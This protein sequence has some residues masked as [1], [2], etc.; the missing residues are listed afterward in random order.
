MNHP[1]QP[2]RRIALATTLGALLLGTLGAALAPRAA[3]AQSFPD[4]P[5]HFIIPYTPGGNTDPVVR[6]LSARMQELLGQPLVL[7]YKPGA[8]T[9]I[10]A[11]FVA[12]S[13]PDGYTLFLASNSLAISPS[14]YKNLSYDPLRDLI[15][16]G[17]IGDSPFTL[18]VN[19][20]LAVNNVR[21]L[22]AYAKANPGKLSFGS[23]GNG[24][25]VHLGMELFKSLAGVDMLHVPYNGG[26]PQMNA[27]LAGDIQV[28]L[29]PASNFVQHVAT[30]RVRM[31]AVASRARVPGL[32]LPTVI[33]AGVPGYQS[34]V[35]MALY[36]ASGT[37][38][39]VIDKLNGALNTALRERVLADTLQKLGMVAMP[40]TPEELG[41]MFNEEVQRWQSIVRTAN[42][43]ID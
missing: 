25:V 21:E 29:S 8:G 31:L 17:F 13:K 16:V 34:G 37:P 3:V 41:K 35:W 24:G 19:A 23:S 39:P 5:I 28:M 33:E 9:N 36:T 18:A 30:G 42:I 38:R 12:K 15:P 43:K 11:A 32:D 6:P 27:L 20:K 1:T 14:V 40:G 7:E 4:R 26:G 22:I 10:G 2:R